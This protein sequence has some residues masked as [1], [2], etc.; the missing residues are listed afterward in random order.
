LNYDS[1]FSLI[2]IIPSTILSQKNRENKVTVKLFTC[3]PA[4]DP[5]TAIY[6]S[7]PIYS[8]ITWSQSIINGSITLL[9]FQQVYERHLGPTDISIFLLTA[10]EWIA[11]LCDFARHPTL[12]TTYIRVPTYMDNSHGF[13]MA[14]QFLSL[15]D[16]GLDLEFNI[17]IAHHVASRDECVSF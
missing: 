5:T 4:L 10:V 1:S 15:F 17:I 11:L 2:N 16:S 3:D 9:I 14:S 8:S 6:T 13:T 7:Q 12:I